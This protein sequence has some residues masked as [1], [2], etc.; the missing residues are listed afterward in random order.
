MTQNAS[1]IRKIVYGCAIVLLLFPLF[2]LG[3]PATSSSGSTTD[4]GGGS[5][6]G[7]LA[8]LRSSFGLSQ[9]ELGKIDPASETMKMATLGLRGVATNLLWTKANAYKVTESWDKLSATLNQIA[10]LQ[11]NYISVWEFQAHNLS[12]N[13]SAEFDDYRSRYH[14]VIKGLEFLLEGTKYNQ[15]NPRLFWNL[16]WFTGHKIGQSDERVQFRR[17]FREDTDFHNTLMDYVNMNNARGPDGRPDNWLVGYLWY[18]QSEAVVDKGVPVT[19][20]RL[21]MNQEGYTDK[22]RS[23][24]IFYSDPSMAL[25]LH[26]GAVTGEVTPGEKTRNAWKRAGKEWDRFGAMDIPTSFGHAVRLNSLAQL[27][28]EEKRMTE[29]LEALSPGL[30]DKIREERKANL[31]PEE[32]AAYDAQASQKTWVI[33]EDQQAA[34]GSAYEKMM[35]TDADVAEAMPKELQTKARYYAMQS[36]QAN[37]ISEHTASY[38]MI[39]NYDYW[40]TRC[41]VESSKIT[42]DARRYMM[43]GDQAGEKGDPEGAKQQYELAW[44]EWAKI[45]EQYPQLIKDDMAEDLKPVVV[46]YKLVLDQLDEEFPPEFKLEF[47]R[48]KEEP[49][50]PPGEGPAGAPGAEGTGEGQEP[51]PSP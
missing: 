45:F 10:R 50:V 1:F 43:L 46:R 20:M 31:T 22:R 5:A 48:Q 6:G 23:P 32:R 51:L 24:L 40:K 11:P 7:V 2:L 29:K 36:L 17:L 9:A 13:I 34:F 26:A 35:V 19:W 44:D 41:E 28:D 21:D 25:I 37:T 33:S 8:R 27:R 30:R 18:L 15:R 47:L 38:A 39:V 49:K 3:Q 4:E 16:G 14:W 42:A 12:Y